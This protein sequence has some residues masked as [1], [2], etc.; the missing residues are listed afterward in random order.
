VHL[1]HGRDDQTV[2]YAAS[3]SA[4]DA[5]QAA[6]A[7]RV[8]LTDCTTADRGHVGCVPEYFEFAID[9]RGRLAQDL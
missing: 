9:R 5:L 6:G 2:P 1:F 7:S 8:T 4:L 3:L